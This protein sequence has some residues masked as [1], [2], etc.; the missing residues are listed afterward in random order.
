MWGD[1]GFDYC[2]A[3]TGEAETGACEIWGAGG[4]FA[5]IWVG[6]A[7]G[8]GGAI[9]ESG[10]AAGCETFL[11]TRTIFTRTGARFLR[12]HSCSSTNTIPARQ[13]ASTEAIQKSF[14]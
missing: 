4:G 1:T 7:T 5:G 2:G 8:S 14:L 11:V 12:D 3:G 10:A 13:S 6:A 9:M